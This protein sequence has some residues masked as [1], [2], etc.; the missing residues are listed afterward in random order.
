MR[1]SASVKMSGFRLIER[2]LSQAQAVTADGRVCRGW[3][4]TII[5]LSSSASVGIAAQNK[6]TDSRPGSRWAM[7]PWCCLMIGILLEGQR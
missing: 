2:P 3:F 5:V 4:F 1:I 6:D 7:L